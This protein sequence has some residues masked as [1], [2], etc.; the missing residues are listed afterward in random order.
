VEG[1]VAFKQRHTRVRR[2]SSRYQEV[3]IIPAIP[4]GEANTASAA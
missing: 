3:Y 1:E 2:K 4:A